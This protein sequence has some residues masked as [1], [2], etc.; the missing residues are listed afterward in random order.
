MKTLIAS[1]AVFALTLMRQR[2]RFHIEE[3][4]IV[5]LSSL[6]A[7]RLVARNSS[8]GEVSGD[9]SLAARSSSPGEAAGGSEPRTRMSSAGRA[10]S[11]S[12]TVGT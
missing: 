10:A 9:C 12:G 8:F 3:D 6:T 11:S 4:S 7:Y 2:T 5:C 1:G